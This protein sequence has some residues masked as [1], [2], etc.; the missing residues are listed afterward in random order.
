MTF[1]AN[2]AFK[3]SSW[4]VLALS[5]FCLEIAALF[6]QYQMDLAPCIMCIYQRTAILGI[7]IASIIGL[8][9]PENIIVRIIAYLTWS[10][11]AIWGYFIAAEHIDMQTNTD[12]FA[13]TCDII[14]NF[15]SFMPLHEWIPSFFAAPGDCGEIQWQFLNLSMPTWMQVIF[16]IYS[17]VFISVFIANLSKKRI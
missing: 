13:F 12:P 7:F 17:I 6:F 15:P 5:T 2:L 8:S 4:L 10:I 9:N 3:R 11:S 16:A 14:P 1:I